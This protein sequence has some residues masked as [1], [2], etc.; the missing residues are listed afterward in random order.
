V[1]RADAS[2]LRILNNK[3]KAYF[4]GSTALQRNIQSGQLTADNDTKQDAN[5]KVPHCHTNHDADNSDVLCPG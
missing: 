1:E 3:E 5:D 4:M 2:S